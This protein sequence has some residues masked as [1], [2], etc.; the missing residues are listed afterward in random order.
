MSSLVLKSWKAD[1]ECIPGTDLHVSIHG[2]EGGLFSWL[3]SLLKIDP[4]T[5][6]EVTGNKIKFSTASLS[7]SENR[8]IQ[9]SSVSSTFYGYHKPWKEALFIAIVLGAPTLGIGAIVGL[10]YFFLNKS[11][12][13]GIV[14]DSGGVS[15]IQFKRSVIEGISINEEESRKVCEIIQTLIEKKTDA[16]SL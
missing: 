15:A 8:Q 6:L 3:L 5:I 1:Y 2:R 11:L 10:I 14:E 12:T 13:I 16:S 4:T 7:G 9:L